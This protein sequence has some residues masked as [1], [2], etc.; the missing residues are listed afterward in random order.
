MIFDA[1]F[2]LDTFPNK[3]KLTET[4]LGAPRAYTG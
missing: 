4:N 3:V 1:I 2:G